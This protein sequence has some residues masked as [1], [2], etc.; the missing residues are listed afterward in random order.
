M[1]LLDGLQVACVERRTP[2]LGDPMFRPVEKCFVT[3]SIDSVARQTWRWLLG[4][5]SSD[6]SRGARLPDLG[7]SA[8]EALLVIAPVAGSERTITWA[9]VSSV[10]FQTTLRSFQ[11]P[12][13]SLAP[14]QTAAK[15]TG[16]FLPLVP[17]DS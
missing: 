9:L 1:R 4:L 8:S 11:A 7:Q 14:F 6:A 16:D 5:R 2:L 10:L 17:M 13:I 12:R 3:P 15:E